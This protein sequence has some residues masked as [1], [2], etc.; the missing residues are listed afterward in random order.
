MRKTGK[1]LEHNN[2]KEETEGFSGR[3]EGLDGANMLECM[4]EKRKATLSEEEGGVSRDDAH[5]GSE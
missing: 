1:G 4:K 2:G 3:M 5:A